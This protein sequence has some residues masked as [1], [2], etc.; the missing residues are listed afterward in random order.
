MKIY[1][2]ILY[3]KATKKTV[4]VENFPD[5][6]SCKDL[7]KRLLELQGAF[8]ES[9]EVPVVKEGEVSSDGFMVKALIAKSDSDYWHIAQI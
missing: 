9:N 2:I 6:P 5:T 8:C 1:Q 3:N 7:R 4:K